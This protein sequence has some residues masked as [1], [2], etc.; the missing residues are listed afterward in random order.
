MVYTFLYNCFEYQTISILSN[1]IILS[2]FLINLPNLPIY[3]HFTL[4]CLLCPYPS[5]P[6]QNLPI[7][8]DFSTKYRT[9]IKAAKNPSYFFPDHTTQIT[10]NKKNPL[11]IKDSYYFPAYPDQILPNAILLNHNL[12]ISF[13]KPSYNSR[14][15]GQF[16]FSLPLAP[17]YSPSTIPFRKKRSHS[18]NY[19]L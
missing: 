13:F 8:T 19:D 12:I 2:K 3:Q 11:K 15:F 17:N 16:L 18:R 9:S 10:Q 14:L 6:P 4:S 5:P 7:Y 1:T